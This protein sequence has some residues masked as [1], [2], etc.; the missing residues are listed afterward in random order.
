MAR[1]I[2]TLVL[3]NHWHVKARETSLSKTPVLG[4]LV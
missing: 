1:H 3:N 2:A 4:G